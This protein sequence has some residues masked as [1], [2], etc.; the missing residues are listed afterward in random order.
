MT[1]TMLFFNS[2][3]ILLLQLQYHNISEKRRKN[4]EISL[5]MEKDTDSNVK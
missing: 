2:R 5:I 1:R 3:V 4:S